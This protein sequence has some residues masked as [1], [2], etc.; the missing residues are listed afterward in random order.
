M[1]GWDDTPTGTFDDA[2]PT[3]FCI[4]DLTLLTVAASDGGFTADES[5]ST[6][7]APEATTTGGDG[8]DDDTGYI[9]QN[10]S[11]HAGGDSGCRK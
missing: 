1:A 11:K 8:F 2:S 5:T 9:G 3:P 4:S 7:W 10:I 6:A